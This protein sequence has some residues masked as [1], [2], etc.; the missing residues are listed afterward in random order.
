M[1][2]VKLSNEFDLVLFRDGKLDAAAVRSIVIEGLVDTGATTLI[3][4]ESMIAPLGLQVLDYKQ[5]RM[6]DDRLI[7][8]ARVGPV[9]VEILG[10]DMLVDVLVSPY[11][12][13]VLVG[14][15]P[16]EALEL[17][18]DPKSGE[19]RHNPAHHDGP[20]AYA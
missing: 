15:I 20:M 6:A 12:K 10:R 17:I 9:R 1:T 14:Q 19:L 16:L 8:V 13:R 18:V 2:D 5:L 7:R 3:V 11:G 4:P